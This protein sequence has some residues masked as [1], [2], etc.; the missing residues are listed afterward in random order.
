MV[1]GAVMKTRPSQFL[2]SIPEDFYVQER[3]THSG[4]YHHNEGYGNRYNRY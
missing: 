4:G 3:I 2:R 1:R